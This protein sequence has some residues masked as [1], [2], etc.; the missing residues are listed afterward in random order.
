LSAKTLISMARKCGENTRSCLKGFP[1]RENSQ[2]L[3]QRCCA[4]L[5]DVFP[6]QSLLLC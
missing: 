1:V 3:Q 2:T 6:V 4:R 5:V